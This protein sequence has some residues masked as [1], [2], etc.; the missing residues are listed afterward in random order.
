MPR[1]AAVDPGLVA[2]SQATRA[3]LALRRAALRAATPA[4]SAAAIEKQLAD[5]LEGERRERERAYG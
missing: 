5:E 4:A 2:W 1:R 3:C